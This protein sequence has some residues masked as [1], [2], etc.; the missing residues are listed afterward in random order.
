MNA[1]DGTS[2]K[3]LTNTGVDVLDGYPVF[4]PNGSKIAYESYGVQ[5]INP[6]GDGEVFVMNASDGSGQAN[7]TYNGI[8]VNDYEAD[9]SPNGTKI[10]YQSYG[11]QGTNS[12]GDS[13]VY[14][15]N[16]SDGT[17]QKNLSNNGTGVHDFAPDWG[18]QA[19]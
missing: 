6:E 19:T 12:E 2:Q 8:D 3:N 7:L 1:S 4:S 9:F 13:E 5:I 10:A 16:A 18:R 17:G 15:V 14:V 11:V